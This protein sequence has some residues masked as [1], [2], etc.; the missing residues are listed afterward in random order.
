MSNSQIKIQKGGNE[1]RK[2]SSKNFKFFFVCALQIIGSIYTMLNSHVTNKGG[3]KLYAYLGIYVIVT[4]L[5]IYAYFKAKE[6]TKERLAMY[7][8]MA[9]GGIVVLVMNHAISSLDSSDWQRFASSGLTL[10]LTLIIFIKY[11]S[12]DV[13]KKQVGY[14]FIGAT[15]GITITMFSNTANEVG[16]N[17]PYLNTT[18]DDIRAGI[19]IFLGVVITIGQIIMLKAVKDEV[20][21]I[22]EIFLGWGIFILMSFLSAIF[23]STG[24]SRFGDLGY[25]L[26]IT[27][28]TICVMEHYDSNV[29]I[30][31]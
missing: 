30:K 8:A 13:R 20:Y 16:Y 19:C 14:S 25:P 27:I 9:V 2:L 31:E 1:M 17:I 22:G 7:L 3:W 11:D 15:I 29:I 28:A 4:G 10:L 26:A 21:D 18:G 23:L 12:F 6:E 5:L 24:L